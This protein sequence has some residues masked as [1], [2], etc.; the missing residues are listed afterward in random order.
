MRMLSTKMSHD[1]YAAI[2]KEILKTVPFALL[3]A[4]YNDGVGFFYFWD[5]DYIPDILKQF[6]VNPPSNRE[7][8]KE[9]N[10]KLS[11]VWEGLF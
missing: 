1:K 2:L 7:D 10:K 6:I 5:S 11:D 3:N 4:E 8:I 9:M